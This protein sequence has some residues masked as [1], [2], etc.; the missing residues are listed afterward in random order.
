MAKNELYISMFFLTK[1]KIKG[2]EKIVIYVLAFDAIKILTC[3][4]LQN[5]HQSLSFVQKYYK[6]TNF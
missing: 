4:V 6:M 1:L 3:W 5:D 2:M